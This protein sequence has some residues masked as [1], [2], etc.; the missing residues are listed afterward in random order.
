[1]Q[2]SPSYILVTWSIH[3]QHVKDG[4]SATVQERKYYRV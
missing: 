2:D 4:L 3:Y 1:M